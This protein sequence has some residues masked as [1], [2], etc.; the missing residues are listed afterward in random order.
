MPGRTNK[1]GEGM[2][3]VAE[4]QGKV[5]IVTGA[6]SGIGA[7]TAAVLAR[8]GARVI[9]AGL[10]AE[11]LAEVSE[12][13]RADGLD[14]QAHGVDI[15]DENSVKALLSFVMQRYGRLD[16]LDNN[17]AQTSTDGDAMLHAMDVEVW[18]RVMTINARGTMLM[19]KH[20]VSAML[21][22]GGGSIINISSGTSMAGDYF[23]PAYAA[24]KGAVNTLTRYVATQYGAQNIRC[25]AIVAGLVMT[26]ALEATLPPPVRDIFAAHKPAGRLGEPR[27]IAEMVSFLGSDRSSWITG[28]LFGVDGGFFA[29]S[30]T[31]PQMAA[32]MAAM[33]APAA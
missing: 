15:S 23:A 13:L 5:A 25:N 21:A 33:Q 4:L 10:G 6:G 30:P 32:L 18:D 17:A 29:H 7:E 27:D 22:S 26:G 24:S 1:R 14:V 20:G 3:Q 11:S 9:A 28:Q 16:V 2:S 19:C 31:T 8:N 12:R